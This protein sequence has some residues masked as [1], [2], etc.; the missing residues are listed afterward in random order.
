MKTCHIIKLFLASTITEA[1]RAG[2][3]PS[4]AEQT[5]VSAVRSRE[6][7]QLQRAGAGCDVSER[8]IIIIRCNWSLLLLLSCQRR[9][10]ALQFSCSS[11]T[12][13]WHHLPSR[14]YPGPSHPS[15]RRHTSG[16]FKE[17]VHAFR[18]ISPEMLFF[19]VESNLHV[20]LWSNQS[21]FLPDGKTQRENLWNSWS[22][23]A[24]STTHA[25]CIQIFHRSS[26]WVSGRTR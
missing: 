3:G 7:T 23:K 8:I 16:A 24:E 26:C 20:C 6:N 2:S 19:S 11:G 15:P 18:N 10:S 5:G 22:F 17:L 4:V 14:H 9:L 13:L 21:E 1:G 12:F 25:R